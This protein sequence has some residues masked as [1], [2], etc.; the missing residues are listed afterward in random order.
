MK[1]IRTCCDDEK[2][3][4]NKTIFQTE[5]HRKEVI[6]L[7]QLLDITTEVAKITKSDISLNLGME[8]NK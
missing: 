5:K 2:K 7:M 3:D 1:G 4:K 8:V 6:T